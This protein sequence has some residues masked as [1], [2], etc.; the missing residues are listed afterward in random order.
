MKCRDGSDYVMD[1]GQFDTVTV[2]LTNPEAYN[3]YKGRYKLLT[4]R[5]VYITHWF[6]QSGKISLISWAIQQSWIHP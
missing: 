5:F 2:D 3:W 4:S 6:R 1:F